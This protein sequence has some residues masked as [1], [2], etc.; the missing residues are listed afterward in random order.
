LRQEFPWVILLENTSNRGFGSAINQA[1]QRAQSE[2]LLLLNP[3]TV[4]H[5]GALQGMLAFLTNQPNAG[6]VGPRILNQDGTLQ[7]SC[8]PRPTLPRET[9]RLFHLDFIHP[10]SGYSKQW[11]SAC[12]AQR[13]DVLLGACILLRR[14]VAK[15]TGLFDEQFFVYSE[16]VDLC[17]RIQKTGWDIYWLPTVDVTHF[18]GQSTRQ[19]ADHMFVEL[20]RNKVKYFRKHGGPLSVRIY[21]VILFCAALTRWLT[22]AL[23]ANSTPGRQREWRNLSRQYRQLIDE[24]PGF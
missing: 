12:G 14:L 3:D 24:L 8:S 17:L 16:E 23:L 10:F 20:Y 21:K 19:A 9:W 7:V 5:D 1:A 4:L 11:F 15:Q 18:G 2:M 6:A 13:V 22:G